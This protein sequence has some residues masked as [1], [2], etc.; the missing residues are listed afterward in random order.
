MAIVHARHITIQDLQKAGV[1]VTPGSVYIPKS[2]LPRR[3]VSLEEVHRRLAKIKGSLAED[4]A[5]MREQ[6]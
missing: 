3:P 2:W 6:F 4:I 1:P 5:K